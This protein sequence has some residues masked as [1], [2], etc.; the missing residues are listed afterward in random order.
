[1]A[2]R[3]GAAEGSRMSDDEGPLSAQ[4]PRASAQAISEVNTKSGRGWSIVPVRM[5]A[6]LSRAQADCHEG[7]TPLAYTASMAFLPDLPKMRIPGPR[8]L[9][10]LGATGNLYR[11]FADP[12]G[13]LL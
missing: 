12:V 8:P 5:R 9:P 6:S 4:A 13:W 1:M 10:F 7:G 3:L 11:F 2:A